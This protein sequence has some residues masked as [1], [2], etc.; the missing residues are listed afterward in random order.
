MADE[1]DTDCV[2]SM[3][4]CICKVVPSLPRSSRYISTLFWL[5]VALLQSSHAHFYKDANDLLCA[6]ITTLREQDAFQEKGFTGTLLEA[7]SCLEDIQM[8]L[9]ELLGLSFVSDFSFS[10]AAV[11][12]KGIRRPNLRQSAMNALR[13]LLTTAMSTIPPSTL[14]DTP[15]HNEVLGYFLAL[16]AVSTTPSSYEQLLLDAQVGDDWIPDEDSFERSENSNDELPRVR[17]GMLG[18][19]EPTS[20]LLAISFLG[21]ILSSAQV[22]DAESQ[23]LFSILKDASMVYPEVVSLA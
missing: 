8:Q 17:F 2:V 6:C 15:V 5:A 3:L 19:R 10:L 7:R 14:S 22:D 23:M 20:A 16:L 1:S 4:N 12:F 18:C 13:C 11:I 9:D 21:A